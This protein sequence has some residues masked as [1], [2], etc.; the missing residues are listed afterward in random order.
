MLEEQLDNCFA[1]PFCRRTQSRRVPGQFQW[2]PAGGGVQRRSPVFVFSV[3]I[4]AIVNKEVSQ[5]LSVTEVSQ[6]LYT[7]FPLR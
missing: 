3:D 1:S 5:D 6:R 2:G 4:G 7:S